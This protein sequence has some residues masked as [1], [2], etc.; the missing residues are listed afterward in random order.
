MNVAK[1]VVAEGYGFGTPLATT[2]PSIIAMNVNE[3]D[4]G[5]IELNDE[6]CVIFTL[7]EYHF[8][9]AAPSSPLVRFGSTPLLPP[10]DHVPLENTFKDIF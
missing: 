3:E 9:G 7:R 8:D 2:T 10:Y 6:L 1:D 5:F 4:G